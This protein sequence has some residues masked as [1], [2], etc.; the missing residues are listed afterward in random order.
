MRLHSSASKP[1]PNSNEDYGPGAADALMITLGYVV[2]AWQDERQQMSQVI[3]D[4]EHA[5]S[6]LGLQDDP[7]VRERNIDGKIDQLI[8]TGMPNNDLVAALSTD[9]LSTAF[10]VKAVTSAKIRAVGIPF[11]D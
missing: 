1:A 5:I 4:Y 2:S 11:G 8:A 6:D 3:S 7:V 10:A 9:A